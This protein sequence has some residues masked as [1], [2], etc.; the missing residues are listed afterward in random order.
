MIFKQNPWVHTEL[1]ILSL[2][3]YES[4]LEK[5]TSVWGGLLVCLHWEK[6]ACLKNTL[7]QRRCRPELDKAMFGRDLIKDFIVPVN[8]D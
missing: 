2:M 7:S 4:Y 3:A 6:E 5:N 8:E 1:D